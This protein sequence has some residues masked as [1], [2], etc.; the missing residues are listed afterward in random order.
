M[1]EWIIKYSV[2]KLIRNI[3]TCIKRSN[4]NLYFKASAAKIDENIGIDI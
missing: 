1:T 2:C 3:A 4:E